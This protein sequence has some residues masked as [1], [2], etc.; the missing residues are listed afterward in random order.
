MNMPIVD[1]DPA[2]T[3]QTNAGTTTVIDDL[4]P[5]RSATRDALRR[6]RR[7]KPAML[8]L[9]FLVL[10]IVAAIFAPA[11]CKYS[12][13]KPNP[14][15]R[16]IG[17]FDSNHWLGTDKVGRDV[18][19]QILYGAR[20]SL[21]V[22]FFVSLSAAVIGTIVGSVSGYFGGW[23][24]TIVMRL[25]DM[26]LAIPY[27]IFTVAVIALIGRGLNAVIIGLAVTGWFVDARIV[28]STFLSLK[29]QEFVQAARTLGYKPA[30]I[31][32][33]HIL[34]NALQPIIVYATLGVGGAILGEAAI[35][36]L[37]FGIKPPQPSWGLL[38][39][40]NK[41]ELGEHSYLVYMPGI[42]IFLLVL[43]FTL[44]GDGL[45]DALDPKMSQD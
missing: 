20:I 7:N 36:F 4:A 18:F 37:G 14:K 41:G 28:R 11:I 33:R 16:L 17:P 9:T 40:Q 38:V 42:A 6:F 35:S 27:T 1:A 19:A 32:F 21:R 31:M 30:R 5:A 23:I 22:G 45:R 39:S 24:D 10:L 8:S 43:A 2:S 15:D 25:V 13:I 29:E 44:V 26:S 12:P 3:A 34:P